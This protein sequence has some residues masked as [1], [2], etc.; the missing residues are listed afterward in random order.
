MQENR[1]RYNGNVSQTKCIN[2]YATQFRLTDPVAYKVH[3]THNFPNLY[4]DFSNYTANPA[5]ARHL[6]RLP[7]PNKFVEIKAI[8]RNRRTIKQRALTNTFFNPRS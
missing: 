8:F 2:N 5:I 4:N 6:R 1:H 3:Q 7:L